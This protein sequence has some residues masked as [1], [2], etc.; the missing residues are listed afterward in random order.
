MSS[1]TPDPADLTAR[2]RIRDAAMRHFGE[3]GFDAATI[4]GIAETAGVSSGLIRHH[5]GSKQALRE[6]CDQH[7]V[8]LIRRLNDEV[9]ADPF[10]GEVNQV[11]L[12]RAAMGPYQRYL[13][14]ALAEGAATA[15][16]DEMV[17][18]SEQWIVD[19]DAR[20]SDPPEV[21][22]RPR[23]VVATA[24]ALSVA[25]LHEQ[26]SRGLGVE[27]FSPAGDE[28]LART[29]LE[30]YSRPMLTPAEAKLARAALDR[31]RPGD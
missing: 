2:A 31:S 5:F 30:I 17:A 14:R 6:A 28:L 19:G 11:A 3:H 29:L 1:A 12:A 10:G 4:R 27:V 20:R 9:R 15:V 21:Q 7:L 23:A 8:A 13:G 24:M 26:I 22:A 18:L 25:V 16:F